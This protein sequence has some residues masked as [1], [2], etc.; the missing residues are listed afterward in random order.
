VVIA[1]AFSL[2]RQAD[3][4]SLDASSII[5]LHAR[6]ARLRSLGSRQLPSLRQSRPALLVLGSLAG[7]V[8]LL[9]AGGG[10]FQDDI[11]KTV[12][13]LAIAPDRLAAG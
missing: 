11:G 10:L 5:A 6:P 8:R 4:S 3:R 1:V 7:V 2:S 9:G 13:A 12:G